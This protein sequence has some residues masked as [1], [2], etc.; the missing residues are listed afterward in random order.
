M[1]AAATGVARAERFHAGPTEAADGPPRR[2]LFLGTRLQARVDA[3]GPSLRLR[4]E[5]RAET[6]FPLERVSRIV[7]GARVTWSAEALRACFESAITIVVMREDGSTL[8]SIQPARVQRA[9]LA[10]ALEELLDWPDWHDVYHC[11]L[12]SARMRVLADWRCAQTD[13]KATRDLHIYQDFVKRQVYGV[14]APPASQRPGSFWQSV[15][16]SM[17]AET[18]SR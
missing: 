8:G 18:L 17:A 11:W 12:R 4:A 13:R 7:A 9:R 6:R 1:S 10:E 2:P 3:D 5:G 14:G 16:Y 15:L